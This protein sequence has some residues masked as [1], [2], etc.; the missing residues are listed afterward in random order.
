MFKNK[1]YFSVAAAIIILVVVFVYATND[2]ESYDVDIVSQ[3][4]TNVSEELTEAIE[5]QL[6]VALAGI[7]AAEA[8][9][10]RPDLNLYTLAAGN[11]KALGYLEQAKEIYEAYFEYNSINP[12]AW[13][14]YAQVLMQMGD[15]DGAEQAYLVTLG[16]DDATEGYYMAYVRLLEKMGDRDDDIET[17]LVTAVDQLGQTHSLMVALAEWY[18][19]H[20]QCERAIDHYEVAATLS[21]GGELQEVIESDIETVQET[22]VE[23]EE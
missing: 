3:I 2:N 10:E 13:S 6:N 22:C 21:G 17:V 18:V 14:N 1:R 20:G 11:A 15:Y 19:E 9:G 4:D 5:N 12:V 7:E 16:F 23:V 8:E